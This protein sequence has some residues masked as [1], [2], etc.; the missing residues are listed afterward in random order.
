M[1]GTVPGYA[2]SEWETRRPELGIGTSVVRAFPVNLTA[3][4]NLRLAQ[5]TSRMPIGDAECRKG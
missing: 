5:D 4:P 2:F 3:L 1:A